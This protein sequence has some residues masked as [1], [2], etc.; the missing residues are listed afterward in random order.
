MYIHIKRKV[1][2]KEEKKSVMAIIC[3]RGWGGVI[4]NGPA[5]KRRTFF[6]AS[7]STYICR[8]SNEDIRR[9]ERTLSVNY[10]VLRKNKRV[11]LHTFVKNPCL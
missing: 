6:T 10:P 8:T 2:L 1:G 5:I 7:L 11:L 3:L 9:M 4:L